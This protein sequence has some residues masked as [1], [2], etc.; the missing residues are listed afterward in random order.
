MRALSPIE[1]DILRCAIPG[2]PEV[3]HADDPGGRQAIYERLRRRGCVRSEIVERL[4]V[5]YDMYVITDIGRL[6]LRVAVAIPA[7]QP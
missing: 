6:A 5:E 7:V 2:G 3:Y 1:A 4:G